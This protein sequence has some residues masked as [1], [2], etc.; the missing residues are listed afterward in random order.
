[1]ITEI[2]KYIDS[3]A[4]IASE[5]ARTILEVTEGGPFLLNDWDDVVMVHF[6]VDP[7]ALQPQVPFELDCREGR[8][9]VSLV[10]FTMHHLRPR[11]GGRIGTALF[12]PIANHEFLN[13]RT[14]VIHQGEHGI[15]FLAEWLPN[16]LSAAAG[17]VVYGLPYRHGLLRYQADVLLTGD[18]TSAG[19]TRQFLS[20]HAHGRAADRILPAAGLR[21]ARGTTHS[22]AAGPVVHLLRDGD[23]GLLA[24]PSTVREPNHPP[25]HAGHRSVMNPSLNHASTP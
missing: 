11:R 10:S 25:V 18:V 15:Y 3:E 6:E 5:S 22:Q 13:L 16:R 7:A 12:H 24:F 14:Y 20:T 23:P 21:D 9:Y 19:G 4:P 8:A 1:M 17:P 2:T